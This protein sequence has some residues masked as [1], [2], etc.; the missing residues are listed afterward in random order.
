MPIQVNASGLAN[1]KSLIRQNKVDYES[2]WAFGADDGNSLLGTAGDNWSEYAKWHLA[3][4]GDESENTKDHWKYPFGKNDKVY[5]RGVIAAKSRAA[6]Q[7]ASNIVAAAD[8]LLEMIDSK[9]Q[10]A[11]KGLIQ[12]G[13]NMLDLLFHKSSPA[14]DVEDTTLPNDSPIAAVAA[15][16]KSG[17]VVFKDALTGEARWFAWVTNKWEDRDQQII[18][19]SAHREFEGWLDQ[20][21]QYA[22]ELWVWHTPGTA[23]K[24]R[25]DWWLYT[26]GFFLYSG[27]L[28]PEE[29]AAYN[30]EENI[31]A[32][33]TNDDVG[34]SHG[35]Y[36]LKYDSNRRHILRYR[37]FE[38]SELPRD[39]AANPFTNFQA[40][41]K[42]AKS[43]FDN[44]VKREY[45]VKRLG[46]EKVAELEADTEGAEKALQ[47][48][49]VSMK[50]FEADIAKEDAARFEERVAA[51][52]TKTV[53][54]RT[55]AIADQII[56]AMNPEGLQTII[57]GIQEKLAAH[58]T[59]LKQISVLEEAV[60]HLKETEDARIAEVIAPT[61]PFQ[62][63]SKS[64]QSVTNPDN[65][66]GAVD[67][68]KLPSDLRND[69]KQIKSQQD[70][71]WMRNAFSL[72]P[73]T[74]A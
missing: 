64:V 30:D 23:R 8:M 12:R 53:E 40:I 46:A 3:V 51:A 25:A 37:T 16:R 73:P 70:T 65:D 67:I 45:L 19:D 55:K 69:A 61:S 18:T 4:D 6:Q 72:A 63:G 59:M 33:D 26:H 47:S 2:D 9:Q 15:N 39:R 7:N 62:W 38:V 49:G 22:P 27:V 57:L 66:D 13:L 14:V 32:L 31:K 5:R 48:L 43:M 29:A 41:L 20:N 24:N 44:P 42:E 50:E 74:G 10:Q 35:F 54:A 11:A 71:S 21:P 36:V 56:A 68:D 17:F 34:M 52:V 58:D 60:E 1:A 28:S